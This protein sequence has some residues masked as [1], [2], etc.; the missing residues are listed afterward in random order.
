MKTPILFAMMLALGGLAQ[1]RGAPIFADDFGTH[2]TFAE[3]WVVKSGSAVASRNGHLTFSGGGTIST[4]RPTPEAFYAEADFTLSGGKGAETFGGFKLG[5]VRFGL[6]ADGACVLISGADEKGRLAVSGA[7]VRLALVRD[8]QGDAASLVCLVNGATAFRFAGADSAAALE[9]VCAGGGLVLDNFELSALRRVDESPNLIGNSSFEYE[10]DGFPLGITRNQAYD[11]SKAKDVPYEDYLATWS[12]DL[13]EKHSG[14]VSL[15]IV[16]DGRS[17]SQQSMGAKRT[18]MKAGAAGVFSAWL[19]ADRTNFPVTLNYGGGSGRRTVSVGTDWARYETVN[20]NLPAPGFGAPAAIAFSETGTLWIDD[21]QAEFV[22]GIDAGELK[23]GKIFATAY[24]PSELD[25]EWVANRKFER[26]PGV[27]VPRLPEGARP[28]L[29]LDGWKGFAVRVDAFYAGVKPAAGMTEAFLACDAT[30]LYVGIRDHSVSCGQVELLIDPTGRGELMK[31]FQLCGRPDGSRP[32]N[33][34][35]GYGQDLQWAGDWTV[36]ARVDEAAG[37]TDFLFVLPLSDFARPDLSANWLMSINRYNDKIWESICTAR[38]RTVVFR[39]PGSWPVVALPAEVVRPYAVGAAGGGKSESSVALDLVNNSGAPRA[40]KV[41]LS[42]GGRT[43]AREVE[44][45]PGTTTVAMPVG[46]AGID[47]VSLRLEEAGHAVAN[48]LLPLEPRPPVTALGR[49]S[50][51]MNEPEAAFRIRTNLPE[52]EKL[53]AELTCAGKKVSAPAA[54]AFEMALPLAGVPQGTNAVT[55]TLRDAKGAIAGTAETRLIKR[56]YWEGATQINRFSRSLVHGGKPVVP[57]APFLGDLYFAHYMTPQRVTGMLELFERYGFKFAH[58]LTPLDQEKSWPAADAF[59][60][61]ALEKGFGV[62]SWTAAKRGCDDKLRFASYARLAYPNILTQMVLDEPDLS[63]P[64]DE[65]R[66]FLRKMRAHFPYHPVQM[67]NSVLAI[68]QRYA[69]LET[70]ILMIDD[71]LT[72]NEARDVASV[73]GN[74]DLMWRAGLAEGKP[75]Y[76][77]LVGNNLN[78]H[79]REPSYG[80][81]VAQTYGCLAAGCTGLSY[82][83]GDPVTPGNWKAY[84]QLNKEVLSL[85]D[86]LCSEEETDEGACDG[87]PKLLRHRTM[88]HD[89]SLYV[90]SCNIDEN[91]ADK[92]TFTLPAGMRYADTAEVLF[93]DRK[94][95][96]KDG[97]F[98]DGFPGHTRHVYRIKIRRNAPNG[99]MSRVHEGDRK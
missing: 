45:K 98:A 75:C 78:L 48:Q 39:T 95:A 81:Q 20:T 68:P 18:G 62:L 49:L 59:F 29:A 31:H 8:R 56:P 83:C 37:R 76:F 16:N 44:L 91:P 1:E 33:W 54:A 64:S 2:M 35:K 53:T 93:E 71:Y 67:N 74:A 50:F 85:T 24:Q 21:M 57:F 84:V 58:I 4:K 40:V 6:A 66:D 69:G 34:C 65:A 9:V 88:R 17:Q 61:A 10:Y 80:E 60:K 38:S 26:T 41:A 82:F 89:G 96:V 32:P 30:N 55:F 92:V 77:F 47:K 63:M 15:K 22:D 36:S 52:P 28:G 12:L 87:D 51:Y 27:S 79:G 3:N 70:D 25:K 99:R 43:L 73:V 19:K 13:K 46:I 42:A 94:V 7:P 5:S 23:S 11:F 86:V 14:K 72:N 97:V 90:V